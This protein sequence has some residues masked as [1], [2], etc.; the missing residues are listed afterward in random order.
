MYF[1]EARIRGLNQAW[2]PVTVALGGGLWQH[3]EAS[4][5]DAEVGIWSKT[6]YGQ[7]YEFR[8]RQ[9]PQPPVKPAVPALKPSERVVPVEAP[10]AGR[11]PNKRKPAKA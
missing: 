3:H 7:V 5:A 10:A 4:S 1:V 2:K 9:D 6:P 8:V 11:A